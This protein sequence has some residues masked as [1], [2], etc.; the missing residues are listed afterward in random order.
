MEEIRKSAIISGC[1]QYRYLLTRRWA[2][3]P[4][5]LNVLWIMLNPSTAGANNDDPT[6]RKCIS[7]S[8]QWGYGGIKVVNLFA[9]RATSPKDMM[10]AT[11][12]IGPENNGHI[13]HAGMWNVGLV[14]CAW[15]NHGAFLDRYKV[16]PQLTLDHDLYCLKQNSK[17]PFMPGHPLY[18]RNDTKVAKYKYAN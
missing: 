13:E 18:I 5:L 2:E 9:Y 12:P 4:R 15:G 1:Q 17:E 14:M 11:N 10:S 16:V 7:F 3:D 8:R 6:I